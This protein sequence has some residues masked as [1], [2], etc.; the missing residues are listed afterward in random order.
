MGFF[1]GIGTNKAKPNNYNGYYFTENNLRELQKK[2]KFTALPILFEHQSD[3]LIGISI[4]SFLKNNQI[5][6]LNFLDTSIL[7]GKEVMNGIR[8]GKY[9]GISLGTNYLETKDN[10]NINGFNLQ[11]KNIKDKLP[12]EISVVEEPD[13]DTARITYFQKDDISIDDAIKYLKLIQEGNN[14]I[15]RIENKNNN[16]FNFQEY[17]YNNKNNNDQLILNNQNKQFDYNK[18][19]KDSNLFNLNN[20]KKMTENT[21]TTN[22]SIPNNTNPVPAATTNTT[23]TV[24]PAPAPLTPGV[25]LINQQQQQQQQQDTTKKVNDVSSNEMNIPEDLVRGLQVINKAK[26]YGISEEELEKI[27]QQ[28]YIEKQEENKKYL[29]E[30]KDMTHV[31]S[32]DPKVGSSLKDFIQFVQTDMKPEHI[33]DTLTPIFAVAAEASQKAKRRLSEMEAEHQKS[34][35]IIEDQQRELNELKRYK[36]IGGLVNDTLKSTP[37]NFPSSKTNI[38]DIFNQKLPFPTFSS[39]YQSNSMKSNQVNTPTNNVDENSN[40]NNSIS[41][42]SSVASAR[43]NKENASNTIPNNSNNS[44]SN[45]GNILMHYNE[46]KLSQ[47]YGF[48]KPMSLGDDPTVAIIERL[49]KSRRL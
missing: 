36:T 1:I 38:S 8:S 23:T 19:I 24:A 49:G 32:Q 41:S 46:I 28:R 12:Y 35:K 26:S 14:S 34:Q 37:Q 48:R 17:K 11:R 18:L 16:N 43:D 30:F 31:A 6:I 10:I 2:Y 42:T 33:S 25:S 3:K 39:Y 22:S 7:L 47:E 15:F 20:F 29:E 13:V 4:V 44:S 27:A 45:N 5:E 21:N 40:Q 9:K